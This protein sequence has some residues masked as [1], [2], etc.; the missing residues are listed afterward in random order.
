MSRVSNGSLAFIYTYSAAL[1]AKKV[2]VSPHLTHNR[3][4]FEEGRKAKENDEEEEGGGK[5]G[6]NVIN[7]SEIILILGCTARPLHMFPVW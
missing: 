6:K 7:D 5:R 2:F 4:H 3:D 1:K